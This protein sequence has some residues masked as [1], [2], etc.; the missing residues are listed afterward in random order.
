VV[1]ASLLCA[2]AAAI[3]LS[4]AAAVF[5]TVF[6]SLRFAGPI[7]LP[8]R[9]EDLPF[10]DDIVPVPGLTVEATAREVD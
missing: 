9:I 6:A 3:G 8:T 7:P 10:E 2:L 5:P 1:E 4:I